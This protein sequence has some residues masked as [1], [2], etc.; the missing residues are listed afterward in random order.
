MAR[1]PL[2]DPEIILSKHTARR[3]LLAAQGLLP[4]R[5]KT[6]KEGV[7]ETVR[8]LGAIQ[9]DPIN[10][11]GR[12]PDLV[13]QSRVRDYRPEM[14][15]GL[16]YRDRKLV[17]GWDKMA[18]I[19]PVE[20]W[21]SF[22][23][24][25]EKMVR[26]HGDPQ[27]KA[28]QVAPEVL[29]KI[30][31]D[32]PQSSLDF[33]GYEKAD[34]SWGPAKT[35]RVALETL[36]AMGVV[37]IHHRE[38]NRRYFD[39]IEN[40]LPEQILGA[41][42]PHPTQSAYQSWH[43][44]RRVGSLKLAQAH[45]GEHWGGILGLKTPA[46]RQLLHDLCDRGKLLP[47]GIEELP[48]RV[49][50][51]QDQDVPLLQDV[52]KDHPAPQRAALVAPLD[53]LLWHRKL[54]RWVFDFDYVWE[55]YKPQQDREY[56]YYVLPLLFGDRFVARIEPVYEAENRRLVIKGCWWEEN[57]AEE[58]MVEA[59]R[60]CMRDFMGYLGAEEIAVNEELR[61]RPVCRWVEPLP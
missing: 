8:T 36:F 33:K 12:N 11:V 2:P 50:F 39:V 25:R 56:G 46:R 42:D 24:H 49:F 55:V 27:G 45:A 52:R 17:E 21:P 61:G 31:R 10:V 9:F 6:G 40:L 57:M 60:A 13:M 3:F 51:I 5:V 28:M 18:S 1:V 4:P 32:G 29:D 7:L 15:D 26:E 47:L 38:N 14:L 44:Y 41:P 19:F 34:W 59:F 23:R 48:G 30:K 16:L 35:S 37:G 58:G 20:D 43:V 54:V 22:A 53:N